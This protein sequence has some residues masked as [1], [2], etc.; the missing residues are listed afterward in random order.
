MKTKWV[1]YTFNGEA[2][3]VA[4]KEAVASLGTKEMAQM[5][6]VSVSTINRWASNRYGA[7]FAHPSMMNFLLVCNLV[8]KPPSDFFTTGD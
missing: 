8:D 7:E 2:F 6:E 3:A 1:P 4:V 5:L